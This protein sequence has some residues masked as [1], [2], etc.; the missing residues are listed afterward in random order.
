MWGVIRYGM[1]FLLLLSACGRP[2]ESGPTPDDA[3]GLR[4]DERGDYFEIPESDLPAI[5][6]EYGPLY[7][8]EGE[9]SR[10]A[11]IKPWSAWWY[12]LR[13]RGLFKRSDG[14]KSPLEKYDEY[15]AKTR[16]RQSGAATYEEKY[17]FR[18]DA[19]PW[20]G[21]CH[22]WAMAS[23][24]YPEPSSPVTKAGVRFSVSDQKALLIKTFEEYSQRYYGQ[25]YVRPGGSD[26]SNIQPHLL[27]RFVMAEL[28]ERGH[29]F[30]INKTP[31]LE[32]WNVPVWKASVSVKQDA[33]DPSLYH[34]KTGLVAAAAEQEPK[35]VARTVPEV[36]WYDYDLYTKKD[37]LGR[38]L[39]VAGKWIGPSVDAHPSI[40]IPAPQGP[41]PHRSLNT[42]L[43][44][45]IV[46]EILRR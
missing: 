41:I 6:R 19:E 22:A 17:L 44:A 40:L 42:E 32:V 26:W 30:I 28:I 15:V 10:E 21:R 20:E 11:A 13:D 45:P 43:S 14:R 5:Y 18:P 38:A 24:L 46:E 1:L 2:E 37:H 16:Q 34:V 12:P 8:T 25:R 39:V 36:N 29:P 35:D 3:G 4:H 9:W 7:L 23:L 27:H 31:G 33:K